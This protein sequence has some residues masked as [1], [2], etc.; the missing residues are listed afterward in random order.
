MDNQSTLSKA[1][2]WL[3]GLFQGQEAPSETPLFDFYPKA[4]PF[5]EI[6]PEASTKGKITSYNYI[7]DKYGDTKSKKK[8]GAWD[9]QLT[10]DSL[11]VSPDIEQQFIKA[12]IKPMTPVLLT[13]ADGTQVVRYWDDRTMQDKKAIEKFGKPLRGRFDFNMDRGNSPHEKDD[14]AVVSFKPYTPINLQP[15]T[16]AGA[17]FP[18]KALAKQETPAPAFPQFQIYT[19]TEEP[20]NKFTKFPTPHPFVENLDGS[21]SNVKLSTFGIDDKTYVIPTMVNGKQMTPKQ[22]LEVAK[23]YGIQNYPSFNTQQS[24]ELWI[25]ENHGNIAEDGSVYSNQ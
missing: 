5:T 16:L 19:K 25:K 10:K 6:V 13:L 8:I 17:F 3:Q 14:M 24:A 12:G 21:R 18:S 23:K 20:L 7:G 22:S 15:Q 2:G 11:A 1:I 4:R 9:N